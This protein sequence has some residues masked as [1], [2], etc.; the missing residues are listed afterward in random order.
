MTNLQHFEQLQQPRSDAD[1]QFGLVWAYNKNTSTNAKQGDK[2]VTLAPPAM[3]KIGSGANATWKPCVIY[4]P[5][6]E[7]T[8]VFC[9]DE[10]TFRKQF[11]LV[12]K[13]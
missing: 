2:Y 1:I 6:T 8:K 3:M 9:R 7:H 5:V 13:M 10:E 4:A 12:S 11:V